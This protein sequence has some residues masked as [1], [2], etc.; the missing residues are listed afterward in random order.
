VILPDLRVPGGKEQ[1]M[2]DAR[3]RTDD[4]VVLC[5]NLSAR[6]NTLHLLSYRVDSKEAFAIADEIDQLVRKILERKWPNCD[7]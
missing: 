4:S 7:P 6:R 2:T 3:A 1:F 5:V